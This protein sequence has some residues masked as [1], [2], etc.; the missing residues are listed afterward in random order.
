MRHYS[1]FSADV[2]RFPR[3]GSGRRRKLGR[4]HR[5]LKIKGEKL[6]IYNRKNVLYNMYGYGSHEKVASERLDKGM[7]MKDTWR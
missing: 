2:N 3:R 7:K 1:R 4:I 5:K 6:A